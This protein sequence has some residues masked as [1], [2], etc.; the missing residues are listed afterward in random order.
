M[1]ADNSN[2]NS[3][4]GCPLDNMKCHGKANFIYRRGEPPGI[5][6]KRCL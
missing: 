4:L 1:F 3:Y 2:E 6:Y 5:K